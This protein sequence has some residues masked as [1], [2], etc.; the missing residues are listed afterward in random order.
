[1]ADFNFLLVLPVV[2]LTAYA[3][4]ALL[5]VPFLRGNSRTLALVSLV[6]LGMTGVT[7]WKLW[8]VWR[9]VGPME[10]AF[11]LVRI[12]GFGLFF[13]FILLIVAI[14]SVLV[15]MTFLEREHADQGEFYALILFCVAGMFLM[16][17]TTHLMMVLIGLEVFSLALYVMTGLT[18]GRVRSIESA[19]KYFL[20]GA[21]SS[22]FMVYGMA[23]LYG[24]T[25]SLDMLRISATAAS[26]PGP[27]LWV[28]MGLVLIGLAFKIAVV[29]FHQWVPDVYQ[30]APTNVTG[31]MAAATKTVAFAVLVRFLVGAFGDQSEIWV[32]MITW[33]AILTMTVANLVA[34]AQTNLK[35]MLAYS[36]IAHAG[37]LLIAL[38]CRPDDG[39]RAILFYLAS[40]AFMTVGAFAVLAAVGRG[41]SRIGAGLHPARVVRPGLAASGARPGDAVLPVLAGRDPAHRRLPRQVRDLPG[42]GRLRAVPAGRGRRAQRH[43]SRLLLPARAGLHVHAR[44]G[45]RRTAAAGLPGHGLGDGHRRGRRALPGPGPRPHPGT[46]PGPGLS[47]HL[48]SPEGGMSPFLGEFL[49]RRRP[50]TTMEQRPVGANWIRR[51]GR[52][53]SSTPRV[54]SS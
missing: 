26:D 24:A 15:S 48:T 17:H 29:P 32:P 43:G 39:V 50:G 18:R 3:L 1:M 25:G 41:D 20:L 35:R 23:L 40:Y 2:T 27:L 12:D 10:T 8:A 51:E 16:L 9:E 13:S 47:P 38:V 28:G 14:L 42:R 11:G 44:A 7:L 46:V 54:T 4:L 34:L 5:L 33:L 53:E 36:S 22:G 30:G 19:L 49:T 37:Y 45:D 52:G 21:F 31:F 6:G